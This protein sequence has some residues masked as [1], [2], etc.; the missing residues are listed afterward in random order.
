MVEGLFVSDISRTSIR[1]RRNCT[2]MR[3]FTNIFILNSKYEPTIL[4]FSYILMLCYRLEML[5]W[6]R[7]LKV[8]YELNKIDKHTNIIYL[9]P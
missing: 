3:I 5:N 7:I 2:V 8:Q 6:F 4:Y 9:H 1:N